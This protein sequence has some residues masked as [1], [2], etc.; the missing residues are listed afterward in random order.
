MHSK[1]QNKETIIN[2]QYDPKLTPTELAKT[3]SALGI[4]KANTEIWQLFVLGALAGLYIA[5]GGHLFLVALREGMG[6]VVAGGVFSVGLVLVVVAGA[7]LFTGNVIIII[8]AISAVLPIRRMLRNWS[9]VYMGNFVGSFIFAVLIW[10]SGL[11]GNTG[12]LNPLGELSVKVAE[13]KLAIPFAQCFIRGV[14]CNMLVILAIIM[15]TM[16]KDVISK[17]FCCVL[18]IMLFVACGFEHCVANMYLIPVGLF[19][20]GIPFW[21][22]A[23]IFQ[24]ILPVT[25]GNIIGG[26]FILLIHPNRIRQLLFLMRRYRKI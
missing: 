11:L 10:Y 8:G 19:A 17:I 18:P 20:K 22:Q 4:K 24:N 1:D 9:T 2:S 21:K 14:F 25:L 7:E 3:I 13:A 5:F 23:V 15:A 12:S 16:S 26:L 6:K